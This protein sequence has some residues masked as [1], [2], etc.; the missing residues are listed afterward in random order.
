MSVTL[1]QMT[2]T[3]TP[4]RWRKS[5][6]YYAIDDDSD[7]IFLPGVAAVD[8]SREVFLCASYDG[9]PMVE[10][11]GTV[12]YPASWMKREWPKSADNITHIEHRIRRAMR[13]ENP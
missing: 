10:H 4:K 8:E 7:E 5:L 12:L 6:G 3:P 11:D 13:K 2:P 1:Y 9:V